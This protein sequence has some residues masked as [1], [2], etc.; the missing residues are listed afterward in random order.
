LCSPATTAATAAQGSANVLAQPDIE[1][2]VTEFKA[3]SQLATVQ[4]RTALPEDRSMRQLLSP[5]LQT[6]VTPSPISTAA[7]SMNSESASAP[8]RL[9]IMNGAAGVSIA[10]RISAAHA[11]DV[12][13]LTQNAL[14]ELDSH[15]ARSV[16]LIVNGV[17]HIP[18]SSQ[19]IP[20]GY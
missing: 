12:E 2:P 7:R 16:R 4:N 6:G 18:T 19:G 20:H 3:L 10:L 11:D 15:D 9:T 5:A 14:D 17:E 1:L 13:T 8:Y